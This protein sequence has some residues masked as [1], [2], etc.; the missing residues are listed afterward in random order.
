[1]HGVQIT[2][3][4][5]LN[6]GPFLL[7]PLRHPDRQHAVCRPLILDE[8][9]NGQRDRRHGQQ[10][11]NHAAHTRDRAPSSVSASIESFSRRCIYISC[12]GNATGIRA[13]ALAIGSS[14][15]TPYSA[16]RPPP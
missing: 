9:G 1:V 6:C 3:R 2:W 5:C 16:D 8:E 15:R 14:S 11:D 12:H 7:D 13:G 4:R 10:C